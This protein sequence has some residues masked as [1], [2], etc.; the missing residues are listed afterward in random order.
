MKLIF[1]QLK[2]KQEE[3][4]QG[5]EEVEGEKCVFVCVWGVLYCIWIHLGQRGEA[6]RLLCCSGLLESWR[7]G[8]SSA[9]VTP[10]VH[11][12]KQGLLPE[13]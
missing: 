1:I 7:C 12:D 8:R 2:E 13:T 10:V 4:G 6:E 9:L 11:S 5:L 3:G